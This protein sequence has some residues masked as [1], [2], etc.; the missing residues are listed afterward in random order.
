MTMKITPL[1][2]VLAL[3][4]LTAC[5]DSEPPAFKPVL[6]VSAGQPVRQVTHRGNTEQNYNWTFTYSKE[7]LTRAEGT[8]TGHNASSSFNYVSTLGYGNKKVTVT[9]SSGNTCL[10]ELNAAGYI[11]QMQVNRNQY[12]FYYD[13]AGHLISW[14]KI[15][16]DNS[17]GLGQSYTT[18]AT[19]D[20]HNSDIETITYTETGNPAVTLRFTPT[21]LPNN[22]GTLPPT[23]TKELGMLGFEH[24]YYAGLLGRP[25]AH[26]V[27][28]IDY[29]FAEPSR[30]Y[31]TDFEY[32]LTGNNV[33]LCN[34]RNLDGT[35]ASIIYD[36]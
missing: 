35:P 5:S 13:V 11:G 29:E 15:I 26:L 1:A 3:G 22:N 30:N 17:V 23:V 36:Y 7:R 18:S 12:Y 2:A 33:E 34:Y 16:Y 27:K 31:G 14:K 32:S 8:L 20:Y 19:I 21:Q 24:L 4:A 28:R 9:N 6:P 10:V 25:T